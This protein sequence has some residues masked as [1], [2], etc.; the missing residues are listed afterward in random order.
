MKDSTPVPTADRPPPSSFYPITG[1]RAFEE[2]VDQIAF[3]IRSG[4][5]R[6]GERLPTIPELALAMSVSKP[7]VGEAI[8]VLAR[9]GVVRADRGATGGI[10]VIRSDVPV[11]LLRVALGPRDVAVEHLLEA[12]RLVETELAVLAGARATASDLELMRTAI[13]DLE[14]ALEGDSM[15]TITHADHLFHYAFGRAARNPIL[16]ATQHAVL[17]RLA[18]LFDHYVGHDIGNTLEAHRQTVA[19]IESRDPTQI[20]TVMAAHMDLLENHWASTTPGQ[21]GG[22]EQRSRSARPSRSASTRR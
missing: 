13:R 12:R 9:E 4:T 6:E 14:R 3:A 1:P 20:R 5:Y 2:V 22:A 11:G 10:T 16:A 21:R 19:A 7:T 18:E 8:R 15:E 17:V